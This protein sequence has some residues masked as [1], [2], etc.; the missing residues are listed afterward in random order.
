MLTPVRSNIL[1]EQHNRS[2]GR[3]SVAYVVLPVLSMQ[4][5]L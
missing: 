5:D 2:S 1:A 3:S 4:V